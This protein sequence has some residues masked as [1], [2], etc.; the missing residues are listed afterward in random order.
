MSDRLFSGA[1]PEEVEADLAPLVDF[2]DEGLHIADLNLHGGGAPPPSPHALRSALLP[3]ALQLHA[4]GGGRVRGGGGAG[5]EP[6]R[7]QLAGLS[8]GVPPWRSSAAGPSAA[9][10]VW[11]PRPKPPFSTAGPTPTSRPSTWPCTTGPQKAGFDFSAE[12]LGGVRGSVPA[13]RGGFGRCPLLPETCRAVPGPGG[14]GAGPGGRGREPAHGCGCSSGR[15]LAGTSGDTGTCFAWWPRPGP[16]PPGPWIRSAEIAD[17]CQEE[18]AWLH[19]D[20]AYGLAYGLVPEKAPLFQGLDR[21]DTVAWDPHKQ[22]GVPIPSSIL[23]A[24]DRELFGPW[25]SSATTGI[26]PTRRGRTRA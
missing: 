22:M 14:G 21:A 4:G 1:S 11:L 6:G 12:G 5:V 19:V 25:P 20:G 17:V 26:G 2:Q 24:R 9:S 8:R 18:G 10:S 7:H 23:F 13:G 15:T 16:P 3:G